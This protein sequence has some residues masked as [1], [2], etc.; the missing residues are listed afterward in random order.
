MKQIRIYGKLKQNSKHSTQNEF[1]LNHFFKQWIKL[2]LTFNFINGKEYRIYKFKI[3]KRCRF[4]YS[5]SPHTQTKKGR[6]FIE[7]YSY[8]LFGLRFKDSNS[9]IMELFYFFLKNYILKYKTLQTGLSLKVKY[10]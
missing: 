8:N 3:K 1:Y 4:T 9:K 10:F 5:G 2:A 7:Y 6:D